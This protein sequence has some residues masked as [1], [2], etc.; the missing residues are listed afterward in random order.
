MHAWFVLKSGTVVGPI[1]S[2]R[3]LASYTN[4]NV[5]VWGLPCS[6]WLPISEWSQ[7]LSQ[8]AFDI[9]KTK[10]PQKAKLISEP[11]LST[12]SLDD[13]QPSTEETS[14]PHFSVEKHPETKPSKV[15]KIRP[16]HNPKHNSDLEKTAVASLPSIPKV[17]EIFKAENQRAQEEH[18]K[19]VSEVLYNQLNKILQDPSIDDE[20]HTLVQATMD[21]LAHDLSSEAM[22]P[23]DAQANTGFDDGSTKVQ[24]GKN[25]DD[26]S[27][28]VQA[29]N[30][31]DDDGATKVQ[32]GHSFEDNNLESSTKVQD[33]TD[34]NLEA[35]E[36]STDG[37]TKVQSFDSLVDSL[38]DGAST[39]VQ[40]F[41]DL[42]LDLGGGETK[43][44]GFD[45]LI[46]D[47]QDGA[48]KL[49]NTDE[50]AS[51]GES[52]KTESTAIAPNDDES[53][54]AADNKLKIKK[55]PVKELQ[56]SDFF[57]ME[58]SVSHVPVEEK[59]SKAFDINDL[60]DNFN[61]STET[62]LTVV[63]ST[64][65]HLD[66]DIELEHEEKTNVAELKEVALSLE[67]RKAL[68]KPVWYVA[69]D[70]E[71]EGPMNVESL[72]K[73]LDKYGN[74]EFI[75][76]WKNGFPDWQNLYDTPQI[77]SQ[78]GIGFRRH[79][80]F[81]FSGTVKIE[82]NGNVQIG[83]LENLSFSG[84]GATGFGPLNLGDIVKVTLDCPEL[85]SEVEFVAKIRFS[86][87][88]GV[89]GLS[90]VKTEFVE[91]VN[92]VIALVQNLTNKAAA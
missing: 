21:D 75:Y 11:E 57:Q 56:A 16:D 60:K 47:L 77:S 6:E 87:D 45:D 23:T 61:N 89:L 71:S 82:F 55:A 72:L 44:Q 92:K 41:D 14:Y 5:M 46:S 4:Q 20:G 40:S 37:A 58:D 62:V 22:N 70:G 25:F 39:K 84:L 48:T 88:L 17:D 73:K 49:Q 74:P 15:F 81:P 18:D 13:L 86:S 59:K 26:G 30:V 12:E 76:I 80:R 33:F 52:L 2:E 28:K 8:G 85:E 65:S 68:Q 19:E 90:F 64:P 36:S 34:F 3:V 54:L 50:L 32:P 29:K 24:A 43:V 83:Q 10:A 38:E 9:Q 7:Q 91:N 78:L 35:S 42:S 27:T 1:T 53:E 63:D 51:F 66:H 31:F 79:D 67:Q 69:Y